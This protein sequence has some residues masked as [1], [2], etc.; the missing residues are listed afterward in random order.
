MTSDLD[1]FNI[2]SHYDFGNSQFQ[3]FIPSLQAV[4]IFEGQIHP[5]LD[6]YEWAFTISENQQMNIAYSDV[7]AQ[8]PNWRRKDKSMSGVSVVS[9]KVYVSLY[10]MDLS[11]YHLLVIESL[12][13]IVGLVFRRTTPHSKRRF[14]KISSQKKWFLTFRMILILYC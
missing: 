6:T 1:D 10:D 9:S 12:S 5:V 3:I 8:L 13:K 7:F 4:R 11:Q 14:R 2:V